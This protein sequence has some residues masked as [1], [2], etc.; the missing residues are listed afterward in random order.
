MVESVLKKSQELWFFGTATFKS[1]FCCLHK[2][3]INLRDWPLNKLK[4]HLLTT[5]NYITSMI[6]LTTKQSLFF[7]PQSCSYETVS[8]CSYYGEF[9]THQ[10]FLVFSRFSVQSFLDISYFLEL[11]KY[12]NSKMHCFFR[13]SRCQYILKILR[14]RKLK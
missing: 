4:K 8:E 6:K 9:I 13:V 3:Y 5:T 14:S 1:W 10:K 7:F 2:K 11:S 12:S